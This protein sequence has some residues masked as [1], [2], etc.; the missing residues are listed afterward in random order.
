MRA[1]GAGGQKQARRANETPPAQHCSGVP[2]K[3][4]RRQTDSR[5]STR[6]G[7][8]VFGG[9]RLQRTGRLAGQLLDRQ[10]RFAEHRLAGKPA[11]D[12]PTHQRRAANGHPQEERLAAPR[13]PKFG[14]IVR[15]RLP[16]L[17][18]RLTPL[19]G[20]PDR[21]R[22]RTR[23]IPEIFL[24]HPRGAKFLRLVNRVAPL[25]LPLYVNTDSPRKGG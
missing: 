14:S 8:H 16:P 21:V 20:F 25:S 11:P 13:A 24:I 17:F 10:R 22:V 19:R 12:R 5:A 6:E 18:C 23:R 2:L 9:P 7:A 15:A 4:Q 1:L 3:F